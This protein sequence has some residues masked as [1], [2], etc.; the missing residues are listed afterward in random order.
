LPERRPNCRHAGAF[1]LDRAEDRDEPGPAIAA[2]P[3]RNDDNL[4]DVPE[5]LS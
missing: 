1:A 2:F 3:Q 4:K 5:R